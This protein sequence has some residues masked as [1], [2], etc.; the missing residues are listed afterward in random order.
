[1]IDSTLQIKATSILEHKL[2]EINALSGQVII[3]EVQ[4]GHIK[5]LIGLTRKDSANYQPCNNFSTQKPTG[6]MNPI[7]VLAALEIE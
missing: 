7:S 6:L 1:M 5:A 2:S 3:M 4:T